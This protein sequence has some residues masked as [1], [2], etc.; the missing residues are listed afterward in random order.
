MGTMAEAKGPLRG[1]LRPLDATAAT[2]PHD[3]GA[4]QIPEVRGADGEE[5]AST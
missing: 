5:P 1:V 3:T 4:D 2:R